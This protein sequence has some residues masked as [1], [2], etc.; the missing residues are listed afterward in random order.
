LWE[1]K[2]EGAKLSD[3]QQALRPCLIANGWDYYVVHS[4]DEA[5]AI[6]RRYGIS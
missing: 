3:E 1:V 5:L 4:V 6:L 2:L